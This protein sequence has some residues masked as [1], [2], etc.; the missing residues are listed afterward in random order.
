LL[1]VEAVDNN[2]DCSMIAAAAATFFDD[3]R[4]GID[5]SML[6]SFSFFAFVNRA[7]VLPD[8]LYVVLPLSNGVFSEFCF[9]LLLW[10]LAGNSLTTLELVLR[11]FNAV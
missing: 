3:A 1:D 6:V 7:C 5:L 8:L 11:P 4:L 10:F 2:G 9:E